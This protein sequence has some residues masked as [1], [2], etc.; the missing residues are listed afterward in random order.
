MI[1]ALRQQFNANFTQEKYQRLLKLLEERCGT[2]VKFRVCETP[3]FL[4]KALIDQMS[5]YGKELIQ[6]LNNIEYRKASSAA[7]PDRFKVP[8]RIPETS[9]YTGGFWTGARQVRQVAAQAG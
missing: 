8:A 9:F 3:C 7:I 2:P 6:Q 5:D 1:P 4:P